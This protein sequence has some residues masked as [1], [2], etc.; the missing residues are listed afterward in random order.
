VATSLTGTALLPAGVS[1]RQ[2][3]FKAWQRKHWEE[4]FNLFQSLKID[5]DVFGRDWK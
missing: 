4:W 2:F 3:L 5:L 1:L